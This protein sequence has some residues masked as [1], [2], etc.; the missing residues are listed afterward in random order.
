MHDNTSLIL[1][2]KSFKENQLHKK[3]ISIFILGFIF[4][5]LAFTQCFKKNTTFKAGESILYHAYYN[6]GVVWVDAGWVVFNVSDTVY[7]GKN[8]YHLDSYG[9]SH[10][11]YDWFFKVRDHY[12]CFLD[13][14]TLK[15]LWFHRENY[16]GGFEADYKYIFDHKQNVA[17]AYTENSDR[18]YKEETVK[19]PECTY[20]VLS[21]I[22]FARNIDFSKLEINDSVPVTSIIDREIFDLYIRFKGH[23]TIKL[24]N[25]DQYRCLMFSALL[26]EGTIFKGGE[27]LLVWVTDD[28]NKIPVKVE[29][30]I[31]V[32][33]VKAYLHTANGL[34]YPMDALIKTERNE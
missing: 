24:S 25:G 5:Q 31:L 9:R 14:N 7:D 34:R 3:H 10:S 23:D 2:P 29:A 28:N 20:D 4:F 26:V 17:Y 16:E 15:P 27:D 12:W 8:V 19:F 32:G 18:P 21:L 1:Y 6:W 33:S 22:Y 30:R 13:K 11:S